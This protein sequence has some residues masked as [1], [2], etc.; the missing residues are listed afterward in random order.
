[1]GACSIIQILHV[2]NPNRSSPT[3]IHGAPVDA[4]WAWKLTTLP[5]ETATVAIDIYPNDTPA[6][7]SKNLTEG[8]PPCEALR[9]L[10]D[11]TPEGDGLVKLLLP[12]HSGYVVQSDF[13]ERRMVDCVDVPKVQGFVTPAQHIKGCTAE[14]YQSM[15]LSN[16][17]ACCYGAVVV[18]NAAKSE[19]IDAELVKRLS[20]TWLSPNHIPRK[21]LALVG[22]GSLPKVHGYLVAAASLNIALVVFD[23]ACHWMLSN[24]YSHLRE[25]FVPLDMTVTAD[26]AQRISREEFQNTLES[27]D[28]KIANRIKKKENRLPRR[29]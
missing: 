18:Q 17:L 19:E 2:T 7:S 6:N 20:F 14:V 12:V 5:E 26:M 24:A 25:E 1:M 13:L 15:S 3:G 29:D 8:S 28:G 23:E 22:A 11:N 21:R 9:F 10:Q 4:T 27:D 16:L